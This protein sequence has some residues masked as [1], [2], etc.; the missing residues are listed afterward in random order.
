MK[1]MKSDRYFDYV[2]YKWEFMRRNPEYIKEWEAL[3]GDHTHE[4]DLKQLAESAREPTED[5]KTFLARRWITLPVSP[6]LSYDEFLECI[7]GTG[8]D[9]S[10]LFTELKGEFDE[11]PVSITR[12]MSI[13]DA[14]KEVANTGNLTVKIDLSHPKSTLV[15]EFQLLLDKWMDIYK[16]TNK[17]E[18]KERQKKIM[19][20]YPSNPNDFDT[21]LKVYD[22]RQKKISWKKISQ[23]L[24]LN[25]MQT[26]RNHYRAASRLIDIG[27]SL[28]AY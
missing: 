5:E 9:E 6:A 22:L 1:K 13:N 27:I 7:E 25:S 16:K 4:Y 2:K 17:S 3:Y 18:P 8:Y 11:E 20:K 26:A 23:M 10:F 21:Y 24:K 15:T 12:C 28:Y 14:M 19:N